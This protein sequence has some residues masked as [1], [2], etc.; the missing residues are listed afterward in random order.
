M[1][2]GI[3][4]CA[5]I[6]GASGGAG[7]YLHDERKKEH[8]NTN[9]DIDFSRSD[10]NFAFGKYDQR[11]NYNQRA[12]KRIAEGYT[13]KRAVRKD[14]VKMVEFL[15][16]ASDQ[17][18]FLSQDKRHAYLEASY[19]W[20]CD[21]FGKENVIADAVH[22]D[23]KTDHMHAVIV[24]LTKDGRL[25]AKEVLGG[26]KKMQELQDDFY[27]KVSSRF[28]LDRGE[29]ADLQDANRERKKH[30]P[31]LQYKQQTLAAVTKELEEKEDLLQDC[32]FE[33]DLTRQQTDDMKHDLQLL[34]EHTENARKES[35]EVQAEISALK[36]QK[37]HLE[38]AVE[39]LGEKTRGLKA[40]ADMASERLQNAEDSLLR[41][42]TDLIVL[43][44]EK[45]GLEG[46]VGILRK[47]RS[48]YTN[49][50][51]DAKGVHPGI[52]QLQQ[53][54]NALISSIE[55]A[56]KTLDG[57]SDSIKLTISNIFN[58]V[59]RRLRSAR[60]AAALMPDHAT[61]RVNPMLDQTENVGRLQA[62]ALLQKELADPVKKK[63]SETVESTASEIAKEVPQFVR[64][65]RR[66]R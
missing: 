51:T 43:K 42:Q 10:Q 11:M 60:E 18:F 49:G 7:A 55:D 3:C 53:Q 64:H 50:W 1:A 26:P 20:L 41:V 35:L 57:L 32:K 47:Q 4:R 21:R 27:K 46:S 12:E 54:R 66:G 30:V 40:S 52:E 24:P 36:L 38:G 14:A 17:E 29:R 33:L 58:D 62:D 23:E 5:K 63:I 8:S 2:V 15:F 13:G 48:A 61:V 6:A 59:Q 39:Q 31:Q 16:T 9:P 37:T 28:G 34:S 22:L 19:N 44:R 65:R 45:E 25:S 56:R